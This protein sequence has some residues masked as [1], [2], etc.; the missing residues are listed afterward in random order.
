M[1]PPKDLRELIERFAI[2]IDAPPTKL[3]ARELRNRLD[4]LDGR[5]AS[6]HSPTKTP[7]AW[8]AEREAEVHVLYMQTRQ[9]WVYLS[10]AGAIKA[11][12]DLGNALE[13][14]LGELDAQRRS[15]V[16]EMVQQPPTEFEK[17]ARAATISAEINLTQVQ[18]DLVALCDAVDVHEARRFPIKMISGGLHYPLMPVPETILQIVE[19]YRTPTKQSQRQAEKKVRDEKR[20]RRKKR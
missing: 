8:S 17:N 11:I 14:T 4:E 18:N 12:K 19:K 16:R 15:R 6:A 10:R 13:D 2:D 3:L 1:T 5:L 20:A 7:G 9:P